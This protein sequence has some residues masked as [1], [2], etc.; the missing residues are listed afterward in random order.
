MKKFLISCVAT[1]SSP[2][3]AAWEEEASVSYRASSLARAK[4]EAF[5]LISG[6]IEEMLAEMQDADN[7]IQVVAMTEITVNEDV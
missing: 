7:S 3:A 5:R 4:E 1:F 6:E 2:K